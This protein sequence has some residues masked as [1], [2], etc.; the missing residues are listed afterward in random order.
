MTP[1]YSGMCRAKS[2]VPIS[3]AVSMMSCLW[4][5]ISG[6]KTSL[7]VTQSITDRFGSVWLDTW[8]IASPVTSASM[9]SRSAICEEARNIIRFNT[10]PI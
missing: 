6:R 3:L 10:T 7:S 5:A 8:E 2:A 9:C 1:Q 4:L